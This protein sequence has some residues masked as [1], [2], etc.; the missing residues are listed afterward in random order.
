MKTLMN[1]AFFMCA[2]H[3][4]AQLETWHQINSGTTKK[5]NVVDFPTSMVGYIGGNDSL[6]LKTIDGGQTWTAVPYTGVSF[7]LPAHDIINLK[8]I[9][10]NVGFM[11]IG[12]YTGTYKTIDGGLTWTPLMTEYICL[13][14]GLYFFNEL[15]GF[16][17]GSGCFQGEMI[18]KMVNGVFQETTINH[19]TWMNSNIVQ[20]FDFYDENFG[21]A[22]SFSGYIL[23]TTNGGLEWDTIPTPN[24]G[25]TQITSVLILDN[26]VALAGYYTDN[27]GFGMFITYDGGLSWEQ[28]WSSATFL[29]PNF[30]TIYKDEKIFSGGYSPGMQQGV[31]FEV[32]PSDLNQWSYQIVDYAINSI[33]GPANSVV[34]AVG[35]NGYILVNNP[36]SSLGVETT[37]FQDEVM[38]VVP[39]PVSDVLTIQLPSHVNL[40]EM[41]IEIS[42]LNG[43]TS[44]LNRNH[45]TLSVS[46][47]QPGVYFIKVT[48]SEETFITRFLK[49]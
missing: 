5:L 18:E 42:S 12:P 44:D 38:R 11:A 13:N 17:G 29:Y 28:D 43:S 33:S 41:S 20:D 45:Q 47:L 2:L 48:T 22:A 26:M 30:H 14:K 25:E 24:M 15:N 31:I 9:N 10:E 39:N 37:K 1:I 7:F 34:F 6:L 21:L 32:L 27:V 19:S 49:N 40:N 4:N 8:F 16:V 46:H 35:D 36:P 23:R 3:I